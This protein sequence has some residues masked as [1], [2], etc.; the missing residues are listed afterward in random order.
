MVEHVEEPMEGQNYVSPGEKK[1][2][3]KLLDL[4][5][6]GNLLQILDYSLVKMKLQGQSRFQS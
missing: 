3:E 1:G 2:V 6:L 4:G 5:L